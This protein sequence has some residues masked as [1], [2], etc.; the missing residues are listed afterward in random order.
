MTLNLAKTVTNGSIHGVDNSESM[1]KGAEADALQ[2]NI[3]NVTYEVCDASDPAINTCI[4][5]TTSSG[6]YDKVFSN[7]A[8]HWFLK[9]KPDSFFR[10]ILNVLKPGGTFVFEMG[11]MGNVAEMRTALLFAVAK[12]CKPSHHADSG[13]ETE[14]SLE[15]AEYWDPWFFPDEK[16]MR[17]ALTDSGFEVEKLELEYRPT[18]METNGGGGLEGWVRIMGS[19]HFKPLTYEQKE[20]AVKEVVDTLKTVCRTPDGRELIGYVRLRAVARKPVKVRT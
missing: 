13:V 9:T 8:I 5:Q 20:E 14:T 7:A 2:K 10:N 4:V 16:W 6:S 11:G 18:P 17:N 15:E 19:N 3:S 1:I 12:R